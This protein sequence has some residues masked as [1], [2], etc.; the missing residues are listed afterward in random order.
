MIGCAL[1][2]GALGDISHRIRA[3]GLVMVRATSMAFF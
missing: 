1:H 2:S 3:V